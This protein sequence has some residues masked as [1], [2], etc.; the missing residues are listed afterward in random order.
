MVY[1][2]VVIVVTYSSQLTCVSHNCLFEDIVDIQTKL[3]KPNPDISFDSI[4][5]QLTLILSYF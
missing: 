3:N 2:R 4:L 1:Q 5:T